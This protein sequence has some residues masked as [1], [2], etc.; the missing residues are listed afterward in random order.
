MVAQVGYSVAGRSRG[1]VTLCAV[2]TVHVETMSASFLVEAQNHGRWF[3][4]GFASKPL[5]R[6]LRFGL[7]TGGGCFLQFSLKTGGSSF[8]GL[9]L[10]PDS[11]G[12]VIY[13]SKSPRRFLGLGFKIKQG[14]VC[15]LQHKTDGGRTV[16][17]TRRDLVACFAWKQVALGFKILIGSHSLP[18]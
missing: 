6:F 10:K 15:R 9:G 4:S 5:V 18:L 14:L 1:W 13:V 7:K 8:P 12:L 3:V 11:S 2:C 16:Q 17:N